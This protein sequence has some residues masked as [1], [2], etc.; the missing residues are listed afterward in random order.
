MTWLSDFHYAATINTS[1]I[2]ATILFIFISVDNDL[3]AWTIYTVLF[4]K[5]GVT[6]KVWVEQFYCTVIAKG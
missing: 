5:E 2:V 6:E 3:N 1:K 4:L